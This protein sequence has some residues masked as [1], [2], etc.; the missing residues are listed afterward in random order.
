MSTSISLA[1]RF[2]AFV[3]A[4]PP[5]NDPRPAAAASPA[6]AAALAREAVEL[7]LEVAGLPPDE[8]GVVFVVGAQQAALLEATFLR[9]PD[10]KAALL[11]APAPAL[12]TLLQAAAHSGW[13]A[14]DPERC[15][16][17]D[18]A[19]DA[20]GP[21]ARPVYLALSEFLID[22]QCPPSAALPVSDDGVPPGPGA[23]LG[24]A[25]LADDLCLRFSAR[26]FAD[27][28]DA[29]AIPPALLRRQADFL[30]ESRDFYHALKFYWPLYQSS[31][32]PQPAWRILEC[33]S[34]L[35]CPEWVD[36][37][38][39][40]P[41][42]TPEFRAQVRAELQPD[43]D[44]D[45]ALRA[46]RS[47]RNRTALLACSP[48]QAR[49]LTAPPRNGFAL[50]HV[51]NVPWKIA[52]SPGRGTLYLE[53]GDYRLLVRTSGPTLVE[54]TPA[55]TWGECEGAIA[56][57]RVLGQ[58]PVGVAG[59]VRNAWTA[60]LF[61][62]LKSPD[63]IPGWVQPIFLIETDAAA[64]AALLEVADLSQFLSPARLRLFLGPSALADF[65]QLLRQS[66]DVPPIGI[67]AGLTRQ[68][69]DQLN[70]IARAHMA[71]AA[72]LK[73]QL[74]LQH[75]R[76][77][78][79]RTVD[80]LHG[81]AQ[82]PLRVFF[83]TSIYTDVLQF[84]V[85]DLA[86]GF[87]ALG[88]DCFVLSETRPGDQVHPASL[89]AKLLEFRADVL[90]LLDHTRA[91]A[92]AYLPAGLP[93]VTWIQDDLPALKDPEQIAKLGPVD[94]AYALNT[95]VQADF[96][97]RGYP[98]VGHLPFAVN[99]QHF[100]TPSAPRG[101]RA[102]VV[103][104]TNVPP[105]PDRSDAPL[106]QAALERRLAA[107]AQIP[108]RDGEIAP[109]LQ[110]A[111]AEVG[112]APATPEQQR[113]LTYWAFS[114]AR[115]LDRLRVADAL[116]RAK[117]PLALYGR[118][119]ETIARFAP[120]HRGTVAPGAP[121]R[122][123][124]ATHQVVLHINRGCN[125]HPRLLEGLLAGAF[126]LGR[127]DPTDELPGETID[128]FVLGQELILFRDEADLVTLA[129]RALHDEAWRSQVVAA[130]QA[131]IRR[132]HTFVRRAEVILQDLRRLLP[133]ALAAAPDRPA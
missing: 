120:F 102:E 95:E 28:Y 90:V 101:R 131:R 74:D 69:D 63:Q 86:E 6:A 99:P 19:P 33:W 18:L 21:A 114:V 84:M 43:L 92:L 37:W 3:A 5:G 24:P 132:D 16:V 54:A 66:P 32:D 133:A 83:S 75:D 13:G 45:R 46:A 23:P 85:A 36:L 125:L 121:I 17:A 78:L 42:F 9:C 20:S 61:L 108:L 81:R 26:F 35:G 129:E 31:R 60:Q 39:D 104:A 55:P 112:L 93:C 68:L 89:A 41:A 98:F 48:A 107:C 117:I 79:Q 115:R 58:P 1:Q 62:S 51:A 100:T 113:N 59:W 38:L 10:L 77:A 29:R 14:I 34:E 12:E 53:R 40:Q 49:Q 27:L 96:T 88:H 44:D 105:L 87:R 47:A 8:V 111:G 126:V 71:E 25:A 128:Q 15:F 130:A 72:A 91:E 4:H 30:F 11:V 94:L 103:F 119:W 118:G 127:H 124:F 50:V 57:L 110:A 97:R 52:S 116:L 123:V 76:P 82:R 106:L 65:T 7:S 109:H 70:A 122:E 22:Q 80:V 73:R 2:A 64:L 67:W 56:A